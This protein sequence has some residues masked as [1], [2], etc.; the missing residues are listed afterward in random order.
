M[1]YRTIEVHTK[2]TNFR[3]ATRI[4]EVAELPTASEGHVVV[5]N[6]YVGI[7]A[8][9]V[10]IT[11]GA[12]GARPLPF[13]AGLEGVGE[14]VAVGEGVENFKVGDAIAYQKI[15]AFSEY[16]VVPA[17]TALK[18]PAA[19]PSVL[20]L[21]VQGISGSIAIEEIGELKSGETVLVTAA[22]GGTGQFV[23]QLAK[24]AGNHVIGTTSSDEKAEVLKSLGVDRVINY[25]KENIAEVL[26][27][28]Y[29]KGVDLVFETVGGETFKA[30]AQNIAVHGRIVVFG[31]ISGYLEGDKTPEPFLVNQLNPILLGRSA[32][33]RGFVLNNHAPKIPDHFAKL[34]KLIAEG[35]LKPGVDQTEFKGLEGIADAIDY[36][37]ARKNIGKLAIKLV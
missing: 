1:P 28:E 19:E 17:A 31:Y 5:K 10:N 6:H 32:S 30:A 21:L 23:V 14:V 12:Y 7:N 9:D 4:V 22:A 13:S 27:N 20:P 37:Y 15:G 16:V 34:F 8:T 29:P 3:E 26:K 24:L 33:V 2:S 25:N 36:M 11:N 18:V 35:K